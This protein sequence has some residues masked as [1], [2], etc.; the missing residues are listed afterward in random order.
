[1][2]RRVSMVRC[3]RLRHHPG[4]ANNQP[5]TDFRSVAGFPVPKDVI[6][7]ERCYDRVAAPFWP[8]EAM[9]GCTMST[10]TKPPG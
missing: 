7:M 6:L 1:M 2:P 10:E 3:P 9:C 8:S 4:I 5:A